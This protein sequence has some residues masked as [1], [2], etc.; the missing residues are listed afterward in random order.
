MTGPV[1]GSELRS[2]IA[3]RTSFAIASLTAATLTIIAAPAP[4]NSPNA[5]APIAVSTSRS[6][7]GAALTNRMHP[8]ISPKP[9]TGHYGSSGA[10]HAGKLTVQCGQDHRYPRGPV[11]RDLYGPLTISVP[12]ARAAAANIWSSVGGAD[13]IEPAPARAAHPDRRGSS[14]TNPC[15]RASGSFPPARVR[16]HVNE[17]GRLAARCRNRGD[18]LYRLPAVAVATFQGIA[19]PGVREPHRG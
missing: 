9:D 18:D 12:S 6:V 16:R 1:P 5:N 11:R 10:V 4:V 8:A 13:G 7:T 2:P 3:L 15:R 19:G 17:P 14:R